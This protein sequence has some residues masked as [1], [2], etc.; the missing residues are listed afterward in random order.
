MK[1]L[2][3][4]CG[5]KSVARKK[6]LTE[7]LGLTL[8]KTAPVCVIVQNSMDCPYIINADRATEELI[9]IPRRKQLG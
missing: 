8:D 4:E 7:F 6:Y 3:I 2:L 9:K 5:L 1:Q